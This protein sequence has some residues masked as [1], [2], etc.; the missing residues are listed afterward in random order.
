MKRRTK[1]V[2]T[3]GAQRTDRDENQTDELGPFVGGVIPHGELLARFIAAGADIIR[4]NMSFASLEKPYG[5]HEREHLAWL[6]GQKDDAAAR[7]AVLADLPGP[8]I[9]LGDVVLGD[10]EV[11]KH[12]DSLFLSF[13]EAP[14]RE[15]GAT[16]LVY[17]R[18]FDEGIHK[19]DGA[20]NISDYVRRSTGPV[21]LSVGDGRLE[22]KAVEPCGGGVV[23]CEVM[24]DLASAGDVAARKGLTI[25]QASVDVDSFQEADR[26]ALDFLLENAG[27]LLA[28]VAVSFAQ[29]RHDILAVKEHIQNHTV[30]QTYLREQR[31]INPQATVRVVSPGVIAKIETRRAWKNINEILDVADG[32]MV[33][34]GDLG[35]QIPPEEVPEVQ[36]EL[37]RLCNARGK[38]VITATQMLD[39]MEKKPVPTRAEAADVFNAILD[40]TDAV[41]LSGETSVGS[42][43]IRAI[44][45]MVRIAERAEHYYFMPGHRCPFEQIVSDSA[46][47]VEEVTKRLYNEEEKAREQS[48]RPPPDAQRYHSWEAD[49]YG[50]KAVMSEKQG[51]TDRICEAAC[52][53]S[54]APGPAER[55]PLC[56]LD[57][58]AQSTPKPIVVP[59]TS[60]R[61]AF[62][63]SRFRPAGCIIGAA[64][65]ERSYRKLL[66][67]F[68][69][70]PVLIGA[71]QTDSRQTVKDAAREAVSTNLL[72]EGDEFVATAG[73]P[74]YIPGTTNLIQLLQIQRQEDEQ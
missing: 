2:A 45:T 1:I 28:F 17:E 58:S 8:K 33:A 64:H 9:R 18:P 16:V 50:E 55:L 49:L 11:L 7:V 53:L 69:I 21:I 5:L 73:T 40:G 41:M 56:S 60:G 51:T 35:E 63:I 70:S 32:V 66:L 46:S 15:P 42:Y 44:K 57:A 39:S 12:G 59:T 23:R 30:I 61:T 67:G 14:M 37:I 71:E 38:V 43:P 10:R 13:G 72:E 36:K 26:E 74:L 31:R 25:R 65:Y 62:M 68:G 6:T 47:L 48:R 22:L 34:R 19:V 3:A 54:E 27:E 29:N 52:L 4:L 20:K 24:N